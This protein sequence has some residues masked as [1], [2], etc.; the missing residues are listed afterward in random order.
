M[1]DLHSHILPYV[2]D[3]ANTVEESIEILKDA[4]NYGVTD[5]C[6]TP[7]FM[8]ATDYAKDKEEIKDVYDELTER[9]KKINLNINLYLGNEVF[10]ENNMIE[11]IKENKIYLLNDSKYILFELPR[12]NAY[13]GLYDI[14]FHLKSNNY[15]PI[16][17]HPERYKVILENPNIAYELKEQGVLFQ[18]N[19]GSFVGIYGK[20][21]Q[22]L[23]IL[24][25]K[26]HCIDFIASDVHHKKHMHYKYIN[27]V[28]KLLKKYISEDEIEKLFVKNPKK[29]LDNKE[30]LANTCF[31]FKK[32]IIGKWK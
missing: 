4:Y 22:S 12:L 18:A 2:D 3:G 11:L 29:V 28:R 26:H 13:Q 25:L 16:L 21:I 7:H 30:V 8:Y 10:V 24:L 17:A 6:L 9:M 23:A 20:E 31:P 15:E 32:S 27:E 5:I 14:V 1:I 19:I